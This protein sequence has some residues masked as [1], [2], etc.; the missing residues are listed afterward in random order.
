MTFSFHIRHEVTPERSREVFDSIAVGSGYDHVTQPERQETRLRQLGLVASGGLTSKGQAVQSACARTPALWGDLLHYLHYGLWDA[1]A[2]LEN[3]FSWTYR[4]FADYLWRAGN[5]CLDDSFWEPVVGFFIG[6]IEASQQFGE[7]VGSTTREGSVSLS[8]FSLIGA[9]HWLKAVSPPVIENGVFAR[10]HFCPP[11]LMVLAMCWVGQTLGGE[12]GV[13]FLLTPER[14]EAI[15]R[16]CL[17]E[18]AALDRVLD[19][20]LP[21][22]PAIVRPGTG[23]GVYGRFIRFL[24]WPELQD[25]LH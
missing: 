12:L 25:L 9:T 23:A 4:H 3:V 19:W 21:L 11:E 15:C 8:K 1:H 10:R 7:A 5:V 24:E 18:P 6:E 20:T 16:L 17:L 22:H 13:D 2:P 14:R